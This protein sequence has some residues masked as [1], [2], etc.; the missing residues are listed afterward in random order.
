MQLCTQLHISYLTARYL[1]T[2]E[3]KGK[4]TRTAVDEIKRDFT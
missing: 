1:K 4:P 3:C 2:I